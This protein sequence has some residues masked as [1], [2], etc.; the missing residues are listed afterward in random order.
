MDNGPI[1]MDDMMEQHEVVPNKPKNASPIMPDPI[2]SKRLD[3]FISEHTVFVN[4]ER[5][6]LTYYPDYYG[7][8]WPFDQMV[9]DYPIQRTNADFVAGWEEQEEDYPRHIKTFKWPTKPMASRYYE[10]TRRW[11]YST[12]EERMFWCEWGITHPT[13]SINT[14][15]HSY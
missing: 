1:F 14:T 13:V 6:S 10:M 4:S 5:H 9:S 11:A 3:R 15:F 8:E 12:S 7:P 2:V